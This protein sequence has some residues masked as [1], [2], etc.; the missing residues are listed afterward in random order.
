MSGAIDDF[1]KDANEIRR[2]LGQWKQDAV[3][4]KIDEEDKNEALR[5]I[6]S[7]IDQLKVDSQVLGT[8]KSLFEQMQR[9]VDDIN[10][11]T[12]NFATMITSIQGRNKELT[13]AVAKIEEIM[14]NNNDQA[15]SD[16]LRNLNDTVDR[17]SNRVESSKKVTQQRIEEVRSLLNDG[18][19]GTGMKKISDDI[20]KIKTQ[21]DKK[22]DDLAKGKNLEDIDTKVN[23]LDT[24]V[25]DFAKGKNLEGIDKKIDNLV[26]KSDLD[27]FVKKPDLGIDNTQ[28]N[29][30]DLNRKVSSIETNTNKIP[31]IK[32]NTDKISNLNQQITN[33]V[34]QNRAFDQTITQEIKTISQGINIIPQEAKIELVKGNEVTG[35]YEAEIKLANSNSKV[36]T[37][38]PVGY[39]FFDNRIYVYD[40]LNPNVSIDLPQQYHFL[41]VVKTEDDKYK[42]AFC[43]SNG[44]EYYNIPDD[45]KLINPID[46]KSI[47]NIDFAK[48]YTKNGSN[49]SFVAKTSYPNSE[50]HGVN[51]YEINNGGK[52]VGSLI[53]EFGYF[54]SQ[55]RFHYFN[56]HINGGD[57]NYN[58]PSFTINRGENECHLHKMQEGGHDIDLT[59]DDMACSLVEYVANYVNNEY[60]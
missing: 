34:Q 39:Y 60:L 1:K 42:L 17:L 15:V 18:P 3:Y 31:D 36:G 13:E 20:D 52:E 27:D 32:T 50:R 12:T 23:N 41:K 45:Y 48:Y 40:H 26:K 55:N 25:D 28:F 37:F 59:H 46:I 57:H 16:K 10:K 7:I 53:D 49:P 33:F 35:R 4:E 54:D 9:S 56:N 6:E 21:I 38:S 19:V 14:S 24:K 30:N 43:N 29:L 58:S 51:I 44:Q 11:F 47:K 8:N 22:I 5:Y 2:I